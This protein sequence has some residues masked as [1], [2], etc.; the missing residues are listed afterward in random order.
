[1]CK[2]RI[3]GIASEKDSIIINDLIVFFQGV[4]AYLAYE[5]YRLGV[6]VSVI[7]TPGGAGGG[8]G[9]GQAPYDMGTGND[10][11]N[12]VPFSGSVRGE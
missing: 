1:M 5:R 8:A 2:C 3:E 11:Y 9:R 12:E 6:D 7:F 4:T 10:Q